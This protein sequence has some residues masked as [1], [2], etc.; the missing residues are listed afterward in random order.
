MS[1]QMPISNLSNRIWSVPFDWSIG[2]I[3]VNSVDITNAS[4]MAFINDFNEPR[5]LI[6]WVT[7][8]ADF[9]KDVY[10]FRKYSGRSFQSASVCG[11]SRGTLEPQHICINMLKMLWAINSTTQLVLKELRQWH[12]HKSRVGCEHFCI[13]IAPRWSEGNG[14]ELASAFGWGS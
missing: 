5:W 2:Q 10:A 4:L 9:H 14:N 13:L 11:I 8:L 12:R 1:H 3:Y 6:K 7:G